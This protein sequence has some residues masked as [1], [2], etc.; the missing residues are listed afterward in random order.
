M[1]TDIFK[2][3]DIRGIYPDDI[4]KNL[5]WKIGHEYALMLDADQLAVCRD[6][7]NS[8]PEIAN[9]VIHGITASGCSVLNPGRTTTPMC[10]YTVGSYDLDGGIMITASHN[11]PEYTGMKLCR[12]QAIPVSGE[13]GIETL[14]QRVQTTSASPDNA[15]TSTVTEE[16]ID[17]IPEYRKYLLS[18]CRSDAFDI[19]VAIDG[20]SGAVAAVFDQLFPDEQEH[21]T[22]RCMTPDGTFPNHPPDPLVSDNTRDLAEALQNTDAYF[23]IAFDGDGDRAIFLDPEGNPISSDLITALLAEDLLQSNDS[24]I[25]SGD[26]PSIVYD[27]R[28]SKIVP[29][30]ILANGGTA[31]KERVG[32]SF[33]KGTMREEDAVFGGELS[34]HFYYKDHFYA[35]SALLTFVRV[36]DIVASR[37]RPIDELIEPFEQYEQSGEINFEVDDK[38]G[39]I[40]HLSEQY[41]EHAQDR[42]DGLTVNAGSWWFNLRKSNT[43]PLLRLN[44][45]ADNEALMKEKVEEV[46][47]K[48]ES[49]RGNA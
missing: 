45:E 22:T 42:L 16:E 31:V 3:Y 18:H 6:I 47:E 26:S 34:G 36:L 1:N 2:S 46:Q 20:A 28:S 35:D 41:D 11:P 27:L 37:D 44:L 14:K 21:W 7:R 5:A 8:S 38:D 4:D 24:A 17:L 25:E 43:E 33:I 49:F 15:S 9:A 32:H 40:E 13:T 19:P 39:C 30:T 12:E 10:Y 23:G 48:I 29:E